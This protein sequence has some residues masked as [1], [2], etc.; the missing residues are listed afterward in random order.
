MDERKPLENLSVADYFGR[1][2]DRLEKKSSCGIM[3]LYIRR[4][5]VLERDE[6]HGE[7]IG[8][9][10]QVIFQESDHST[11]RLYNPTAIGFVCLACVSFS[12]NNIRT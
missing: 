1:H 12:T 2:G 6:L 3:D 9:F 10:S 8:S 7:G 5:V 4:Y 11:V